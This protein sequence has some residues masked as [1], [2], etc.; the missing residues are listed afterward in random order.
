MSKNKD[1]QK[2][3]GK[4]KNTGVGLTTE[5]TGKS[6]AIA[7]RIFDKLDD[8]KA[9]INNPKDTAIEG[10]ILTVVND[11]DKN[12]VYF[13]ESVGVQSADSNT[14]TDGEL[15]KLSDTKDIKIPVIDVKVNDESVVD[16]NGYAKIDLNN[17]TLKT[18]LKEVSDKVDKVTNS[19]EGV[20]GEIEKKLDKDTYADVNKYGVV[21]FGTKY[22]GDDSNMH[23][24]SVGIKDGIPQISL[25][26]KQFVTDSGRIKLKELPLATKEDLGV[27]RVGAS[28]TTG[29]AVKIARDENNEL[30][31]MFNAP[32]MMDKNKLSLDI[33]AVESKTNVTWGESS[34]MNNLK[35]PGVY[36][37]YGERRSVY[38][39]LPINNSNP[40]HTIAGRLTVVDSTLKPSDG[41]TPTE[42]CITQFLSL[43]NRTGGDG[44]SY[45]RTYNEENGNGAWS[46][47]QKQQGIVET[48]INTDEYELPA[49][50]FQNGQIVI[51]PVSGG[52]NA[53]INNGM[54]SG[55]YTTADLMTG[56]IPEFMETFVLVVIND[57]AAAGLMGQS[58]RISQLKYAIDTLT[59]ENSIKKRIGTDN[60][61]SGFTWTEWESVGVV[62][63]DNNVETTQK[64]YF[65]TTSYETG[66][67]FISN[68]VE[69]NAVYMLDEP[70]GIVLPTGSTTNY[71]T[72][73]YVFNYSVIMSGGTNRELMD[74]IFYTMDS[75]QVKYE[76]DNRVIWENVTS[77]PKIGSNVL[78]HRFDITSYGETI[79]SDGQD[80]EIIS[81]NYFIKYTPC[82]K[83]RS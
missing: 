83:I 28:F 80:A 39:N 53:M 24:L 6:P 55:L 11:E 68:N 61:S 23:F 37:I 19:L 45:V 21:K 7:K 27:V 31:L 47:W 67:Y 22:S 10:L 56:G 13:V 71:I 35:T 8:A 76:A 15:I 17:Y 42:I 48:F 16:E 34:D 36:E 46:S 70:R 26:S 32:L 78:Y 58:R 65:E 41:S 51:P 62:D 38:D 79:I 75:S 57:Y 49:S 43:S 60:G 50:S 12:G 20:N 44:A 82:D 72:N 73:D 1:Y 40:G 2:I 5:M 63:S 77:I 33:N 9:F 54:Y 14:I 59:G 66:N 30:Y 3:F 81:G 25:D 4:Q 18:E 29:T 52:L 64:V 74:K 69:N